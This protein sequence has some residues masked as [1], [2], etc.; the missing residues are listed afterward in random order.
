MTVAA[1]A[2]RR[3]FLPLVHALR[4]PF[5][6]PFEGDAY[7]ILKWLA[8][9]ANGERDVSCKDTCS[10]KDRAARY[11]LLRR[12]W[13]HKSLGLEDRG[14]L[15][16]C[17]FNL[18]PS[19]LT[20]ILRSDD[21]ESHT[22]TIIKEWVDDF[23][24]TTGLWSNYSVSFLKD[25]IGLPGELLQHIITAENESQFVTAITKVREQNPKDK[26]VIGFPCDW[27]T[28]ALAEY[29]AWLICHD[30]DACAWL[31]FPVPKDNLF[32]PAN[33]ELGV[34][35]C[36]GKL[37]D[38]A[39]IANRFLDTLAWGVASAF[40][41]VSFLE[42]QP[43]AGGNTQVLHHYSIHSEIHAKSILLKQIHAVH[44]DQLVALP[45][46]ADVA[47][48]YRHVFAP[49]A[50][51]FPFLTSVSTLRW[52]SFL[53]WD[54]TYDT[55]HRSG[56]A[57]GP[58]WP[59]ISNRVK[60]NES[61]WAELKR[62][63]A[64]F[65]SAAEV[66]QNLHEDKTIELLGSILFARSFKK[67]PLV[68]TCYRN[69]KKWRSEGHEILGKRYQYLFLRLD[70][71]M[72]QLLPHL[73]AAAR[74]CDNGEMD[75][76][77]LI[78]KCYT[79]VKNEPAC[80]NL[81]QS[82][83]DTFKSTLHP[84][85]EEEKTFGAR[86]LKHLIWVMLHESRPNEAFQCLAYFPSRIRPNMPSGGCL[87]AFDELPPPDELLLLDNH[88]ANHFLARTLLNSDYERDFPCA[89]TNA[90][91]ERSVLST[92]QRIIREEE[93]PAHIALAFLDMDG[94]KAINDS[95]KQ[96]ILGTVVI[97]AFSEQLGHHIDF[98]LRKTPNSGIKCFFG[99]WGG[100]EFVIALIE[101]GSSTEVEGETVSKQ[102]A[103]ADKL[104]ALCANL[105][106][107]PQIW[108]VPIR[109]AATHLWAQGRLGTTG[110]PKDK[111]VDLAVSNLKGQIPNLQLSF[112]AG[113]A[114]DKIEESA[115]VARQYEA[116]R[117]AADDVCYVAKHLRRGTVL[118]KEDTHSVQATEDRG[119]FV[120]CLSAVR[121]KKEYDALYGGLRKPAFVIRVTLKFPKENSDTKAHAVESV[122]DGFASWYGKDAS[123]YGTLGTDSTIFVEVH[124]EDEDSDPSD[125]TV[126]ALGY[127]WARAMGATITQNAN[128]EEADVC[129]FTEA[130]KGVD[131]RKCVDQDWSRTNL[132][133]MKFA[134]G[135]KSPH[136]TC[137]KIIKA[138]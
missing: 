42:Q 41:A 64:R 7:P 107:Q 100:D 131:F 45:R 23:S 102:K 37:P 86:I 44:A 52:A 121:F 123:V 79:A 99:R 122:C 81:E 78:N 49:L 96:H 43:A 55:L 32:S 57:M 124:V 119:A 132:K 95:T 40:E 82:I 65:Q 63:V 127:R 60:E 110:Q 25:L 24:E 112:T 10:D 134:M 94:L 28:Q 115:Q 17:L 104:M 133:G 106:G 91:F 13:K 20:I 26:P 97:R 21:K 125:A 39:N 120:A 67:C 12:V 116:L 126:Y 53:D 109:A 74:E 8:V 19:I 77:K 75:Y 92:L 85:I 84:L 59:N 101:P 6:S 108:E 76:N 103:L 117:S 87:V 88:L 9:T 22:A 33:V 71:V 70:S 113:V 54:P 1:A 3:A 16:K 128:A 130:V 30:H 14:E 114:V 36:L 136:L 61:Y 29:F 73:E 68:I 35:A 83:L 50:C 58:G 2:A 111:A 138:G 4:S 135:K 93:S 129:I 89:L 51:T 27:T 18:D 98:E 80:I 105:N 69:G 47:E 66:M 31:Y 5:L 34:V 72:P 38:N 48:R 118:T 62:D 46:T 90:G 56:W 11:D 137:L 15:S